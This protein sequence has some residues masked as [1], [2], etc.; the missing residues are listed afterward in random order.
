M[1]DW[2]E[3]QRSDPSPVVTLVEGLPVDDGELAVAVEAL[4]AGGSR[5]PGFLDRLRGRADEVGA[6]A[7]ALVR[8]YDS[9]R[10]EPHYLIELLYADDGAFADRVGVLPR[11]VELDESTGERAVLAVPLTISAAEL[12]GFVMN[13]LGALSGARAGDT[14]RTVEADASHVPELHT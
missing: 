4:L 13:A 11:W 3:F 6:V 1:L 10:V 12:V 9:T 5:R 14:W 7:L 8:K 2:F